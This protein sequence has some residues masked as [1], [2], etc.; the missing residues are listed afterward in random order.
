M[1]KIIIL[2]GNGL[3]AISNKLISIKK[4]F[5]PL[6]ILS[7]SSREKDFATA[8]ME[9]S[10]GQLFSQNRLIILE[11]FDDVDLDKL[12]EDEN[13][14][15]VLRFSKDLR[16]NSVLLKQAYKKKA[17]ILLLS[18]EKEK[19]IFPFLD[20]LAEKN[21]QS[22]KK[23][24]RLLE[25][26]GGQYILTM[27]FYLL[28]RLLM[29]PKKLPSF[30]VQKIN[31]QKQNFPLEKIKELYRYALETDFKIKTGVIEEKLGLTLLVDK[32]LRA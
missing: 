8:L 3:S 22:L 12:P 27:I 15:L 14:T 30:V 18:E 19:N 23:L 28:R 29:S 32:I 5:D 16:E 20:E 4:G 31:K 7:L 2:H 11:D 25:E 17:Q 24:N 13:L 10:T 1:T 6:A 9:I 21:P 26:F